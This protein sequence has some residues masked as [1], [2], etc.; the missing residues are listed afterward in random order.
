MVC[1]AIT[2]GSEN[3]KRSAAVPVTPDQIADSAIEAAEAGASIV[4]IHVRDPATG[5]ASMDNGLYSY[6]YKRIRESVPDL[7][8][9]LT[10]GIGGRYVPG[11]VDPLL[12]GEGTTLTTPEMRASHVQKLR[13]DACSLDMG[14]MNLGNAAFINTP[15]HIRAIAAIAKEA[16]SKT[17]LEVFDAGNIELAKAMIQ[18]GDIEGPGLF[19]LCLGVSWGAPATIGSLLYLSSLLPENATWFAFGV[20]RNQFPVVAQSI[21][22]GGHVR[23][24]LEDNLYL[25]EGLMAGSNAELVRKAVQIVELLGAK[26]AS[27]SETRAMLNLQARSA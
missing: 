21:L 16:G 11:E 18:S 15:G 20:G 17:E 25:D 7:V 14:T 24:G 5:A 3:H 8:I 22:T 13:P 26:P 2:G 23:V 9:N 4:H 6:V 27:N 19:Q 1:C 12:P 10:T